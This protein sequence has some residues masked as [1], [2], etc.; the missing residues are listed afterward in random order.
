[1]NSHDP[2]RRAIAGKKAFPLP[3]QA[4]IAANSGWVTLKWYSLAALVALLATGN[5]NGEHCSVL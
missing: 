5:A 4:R 2:A 1:M 3:T